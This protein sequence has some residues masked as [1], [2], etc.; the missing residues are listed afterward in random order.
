MQVKGLECATFGAYHLQVISSL[1]LTSDDLVRSFPC[2]SQFALCRISSCHADFSEY[3]IFNLEL[4]RFDPFIEVSGCF[5]LISCHY[6][7][8][9]F[10][11]FGQ[12]IEAY[13]ISFIIHFRIVM[14]YPEAFRTDFNEDDRL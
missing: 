13:T 2:W 3:P 8:G 6:C 11:F 14:L 1:P 9:I 10:S 7:Q 4:L 12:Q 5:L